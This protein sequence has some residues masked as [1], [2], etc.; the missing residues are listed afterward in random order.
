VVSPRV[1][2]GWVSGSPR[3]LD[4][5]RLGTIPLGG[6]P[7]PTILAQPPITGAS[8]RCSRQH[9]TAGMRA[10]RTG[11]TRSHPARA[12]RCGRLIQP[13]RTGAVPTDGSSRRGGSEARRLGGSEARR[14]LNLEA[15]KLGSE[16]GVM[17]TD[18]TPGKATTRRDSPERRP[19]QCGWFDP[20]CG[21]GDRARDGAAG[22]TW[23]RRKEL[24]AL[25]PPRPP[26]S[27]TGSSPLHSCPT[28]CMVNS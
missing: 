6:V 3:G 16:D 28:G 17:P 5:G 27:A 19:L 1:S 24:P 14:L 18:A 15:P 4:G 13:S 12:A 22:L 10:K 11:Q 9:R 7:A 8:V 26:D 25:P 23:V 20:A 21:V 2:R